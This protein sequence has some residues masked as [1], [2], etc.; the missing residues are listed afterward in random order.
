MEPFIPDHLPL[1]LAPWNWET[2]APLIGLA[3][4]KLAYYDGVLSSII[5]PSL[6]LSPLETREAV[7]SSK[8]EGTIT[9]IDEV[10]KYEV[11]LIPASISKQQDIQE[12]LNYRTAMRNATDWVERHLPF[13]NSLICN[14][15]KE[16]MTGVRGATKTPGQLR[17]EQNWIGKSHESIEFASYIPPEPLSVPDHLNN[18]ID[19]LQLDDQD[20]I[21]QT[22]IMHAQFELIHPFLDGNGRTGRI[23]IPL[24]LWHKEIIKAPVFYISEY[25]EANREQYYDC[26]RSISLDGNWE[27]WVSFFLQAVAAQA[28]ENAR[29]ANQ[30]ISLYQQMKLRITSISN[31]A[32]AIQILDTMFANPIINSTT[33]IRHSGLNTQTGYRIVNKLKDEQILSILQPSAGRRPEILMF[34]DLMDIL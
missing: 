12:V 13:N 3:N 22:A 14:I 28:E 6:F 21:L 24:F 32:H 31:S 33:F 10:L 26:L 23:L 30:V 18:L 19:Y 16:L 1:N 4:R 5:N 8:I 9:T 20:P 11:N 7:I 27:G 15:Q 29:K 34:K 25:L 2:L 17:K